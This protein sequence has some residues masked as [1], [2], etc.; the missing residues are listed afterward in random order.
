MSDTKFRQH[1]PKAFRGPPLTAA[2]GVLGEYKSLIE[3]ARWQA[4]SV[5]GLPLAS[6]PRVASA[7]FSSAK[8]RISSLLV[9]CSWL[10]SESENSK[11]SS[12]QM[13]ADLERFFL[14][15]AVSMKFAPLAA[16][17]CDLPSPSARKGG[18]SP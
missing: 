6:I 1:P 16:Y 10:R 4:T 8:P 15:L 18:S 13:S 14:K 11:L 5:W 17:R 9:K 2:L 12:R 7:S 3:F